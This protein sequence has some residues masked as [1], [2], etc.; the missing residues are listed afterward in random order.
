MKSRTDQE[1]SIPLN[2]LRREFNLVGKIP[3][4]KMEADWFSKFKNQT[5]VIQFT[6]TSFTI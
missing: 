3:K 4:I 6:L 1:E 5:I 2:F